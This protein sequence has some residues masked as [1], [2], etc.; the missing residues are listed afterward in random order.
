[1]AVSELLFFNRACDPEIPPR[2]E[3]WCGVG[4]KE[5]LLKR[6]L[7]P[8]TSLV[9]PAVV[10]AMA[11][12]VGRVSRLEGSE[13][14]LVWPAAAVAI[15][16]LLVAQRYGRSV[17]TAHV[18]VLGVVTFGVNLATGAAVPIATWFVVVNVVL[19]VVTV[20]ILTY[21]R[22]HVRLRDPSDLA[23]LVVAVTCGCGCAAAVATA[24]L[25]LET[26]A[27]VWETFALFLVR[28]GASALIG[29]SVWLRLLYVRWKRPHFSAVAALEASLATAGVA[30]VF[31][32]TFW[33]NTGLPLAFLILVP[34]M[35]LALR[36][37]TTVNTLFVSVA[38][39]WIIFATLKDKGVFIV[40]DIQVRAL[41]AQA[42]V[43]SLTL[44]VLALSLYRD[45]RNR[46]IRQLD[47]ARIQADR[48][49]ELFG[50]VLDSIHD[51]VLLVTSAGEVVMRNARAAESNTVAQ[52]VSASRTHISAAQ[53]D[54]DPSVPQHGVAC[55]V[56]I[57]TADEVR[58]FELAT[59][60][61]VHQ[62]HL[63]VMAF[64]DVTEAREHARELHD[65]ALHDPLT[66]LANRTLLQN[67]IETALA[68]AADPVGGP[69]H[70]GLIYLDLDG[71]KA[72]NDSWGHAE[73]DEMLQAV[74]RRIRR[75]IRPGDTAARL[76]GDEFA[77]LCLA[78]RNTQ[79]LRSVAE[80]I[81]TELSRP[82]ALRAGTYDHISVSIGAALAQP[83]TTP[84]ALLQRADTLM[85]QAKRQG[86]NLIVDSAHT[87]RR[88]PEVS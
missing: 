87:Q 4:W 50:A 47:E 75:S 28:N 56:V 68:D 73:G 64:R 44:V 52:I 88:S 82:V 38:G 40:A 15:I 3:V 70:V 33:F 2:S 77:V 37:S 16:W 5:G 58:V 20:A 48:S 84:A 39:A 55:D 54:A 14:A 23:R 6:V 51:G 19:S 71:F 1:M 60:P 59:V 62:A 43:C 63:S 8:A 81:R 86:T 21:R 18:V 32:W 12:M 29:V 76:G 74:A 34:A 83:G 10:Y 11:V 53:P 66:G 9:I 65:A 24:A 45:S 17:C 57:D 46:L 22:D 69:G 25:A 79:Q 27:P 49:S 13:V 85:Y 7:R 78:V 36:Y 80:R 72:V 35:W 61:L 26:G 42:M 67:R 41:L 30:G 31:V